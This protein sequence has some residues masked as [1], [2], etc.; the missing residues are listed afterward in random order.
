LTGQPGDHRTPKAFYTAAQGRPELGE[1]RTLG[2]RTGRL[3]YSEKELHIFFLNGV[4]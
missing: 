4:V 1:A 3:G 2:L